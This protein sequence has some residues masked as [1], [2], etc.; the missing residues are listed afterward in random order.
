[1][2]KAVLYLIKETITK[3][4]KKHSRK[5]PNN[6]NCIKNMKLESHENKIENNA[7]KY[8]SMKQIKT[9]NNIFTN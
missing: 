7:K 9:K 2:R 4:N 8:K 1:M 3:K 5:R 6:R